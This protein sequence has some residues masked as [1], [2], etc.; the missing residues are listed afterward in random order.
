MPRSLYVRFYERCHGTGS[1]SGRTTEQLVCLSIC[2]DSSSIE[3]LSFKPIIILETLKVSKHVRKLSATLSFLCDKSTFTY[4][5][6][7]MLSLPC[8]ERP[9]EQ[10]RTLQSLKGSISYM[11]VS[12]Q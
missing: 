7:L 4:R 3:L 1:N 8:C 11:A 10:N 9:I 2:C 6:Y 5:A 12:D